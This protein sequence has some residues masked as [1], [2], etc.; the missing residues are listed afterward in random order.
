[1]K[2]QIYPQQHLLAELSQDGYMKHL[3]SKNPDS[4]K[5]IYWTDDMNEELP[6]FCDPANQYQIAPTDLYQVFS[7]TAREM[8][9]AAA[10]R[11]KRNN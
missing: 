1:M 11:V 3:Q 7:K 2:A 5:H 4:S 6:V 8:S 10:L 9:I